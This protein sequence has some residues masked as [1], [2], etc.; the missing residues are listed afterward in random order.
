MTLYIISRVTLKRIADCLNSEGKSSFTL[1]ETSEV[2][3]LFGIL[4]INGVT[5]TDEETNHLGTA[6]YL[7]PSALDHSC[8]PNSCF[9]FIGTTLVL[10]TLRA[11]KEDEKLTVNYID[12]LQSREERQ[13]Q[14]LSQYYFTCSCSLCVKASDSDPY[15]AVICSKCRGKS[16]ELKKTELSEKSMPKF[17]C[18]EC[19]HTEN[20]EK[21]VKTLIQIL[22]DAQFSVEQ[23]RNKRYQ[24][25]ISDHKLCEELLKLSED[26][27]GRVEK[28]LHNSNVYVANCADF[29]M[30][31]CVN[32]AKWQEA[33]KFG[34]MALVGYRLYF[35]RNFPLLGLL[36]AKMGKITMHLGE[37]LG[38]EALRWLQEANAILSTA[39][40]VNFEAVQEVR[41]MIDQCEEELRIDID[42]DRKIA[43]SGHE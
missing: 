23:M 43:I 17:R 4:C 20:D 13:A 30:E 27:L 26:C 38:G 34:R 24:M 35:P 40:P 32:L 9:S 25:D 29:A 10:K 39:C 14:L 11:I 31:A 36:L 8:E 41:R 7:S 18:L 19:G 15:L 21:Y 28:Y 12:L 16:L 37:H 42:E 1:P 6:L 33:V 22:G 3:R 5:I 2:L